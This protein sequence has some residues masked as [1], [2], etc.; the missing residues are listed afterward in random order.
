MRHKPIIFGPPVERPAFSGRTVAFFDIDDKRVAALA[1]RELYRGVDEEFGPW[2]GVAG[3]PPSDR[4]FELIRF[5]EVWLQFRLTTS[6][7][8]LSRSEV[9]DEFL[10]ATGIDR[11]T[12]VHPPLLSARVLSILNTLPFD[13]HARSELTHLFDGL[14]WS[15][16]LPTDEA[17]RRLVSFS[18]GVS[19]AHFYRTCLTR[20][21][22]RPEYRPLWN[23]LAI[24]APNWPGMRPERRDESAR[25]L[26]NGHGEAIAEAVAIAKDH[27]KKAGIAEPRLYNAVE[28]PD[29]YGTLFYP[30]P[31]MP[32]SSHWFISMD[33]CKKTKQVRFRPR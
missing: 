20:G 5:D 15:D 32:A 19:H 1:E 4:R 12:V 25:R 2:V 18:D 28:F 9:H 31:G 11:S 14:R 26:L 24:H 33:V 22:E 7:D 16:E 13:P 27:L 10:T 17:N 21:E 6:A 29:C 23:Q 3:R 8:R 30:P